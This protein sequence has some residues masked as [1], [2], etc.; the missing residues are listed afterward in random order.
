MAATTASGPSAAVWMSPSRPANGTKTRVTS[1]GSAASGAQP[2]AY[3]WE[4][5]RAVRPAEAGTAATGTRGSTA[6][7]TVAGQSRHTRADLTHGSEATDLSAASR[8]TEV[9]GIP[10]GQARALE[11]LRAPIGA[12]VADGYP[13]HVH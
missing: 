3:P 7:R 10:D 8:S 12:G 9:I 4:S 11:D 2:I 6:M 1:A 13:V 5:I